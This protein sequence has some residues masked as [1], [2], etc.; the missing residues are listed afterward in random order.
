MQEID[1]ILDD[2]PQL[3]IEM[4]ECD[5]TNRQAHE[6]LQAYNDHRI[7]LYKHP[8]TRTRKHY[9]EQLSE[10][11]ELKRQRPELFLQEITNVSQNIR[12]IESNIR[13]KK[14]K[15][16][17]ELTSWQENLLKAN[18]KKTILMELISK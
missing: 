14:Y 2:Q 8:F 10:L 1:L 18:T 12:R 16:P 5:I 4:V 17:D 13:K 11:Y 15:T 6:E 7:F 9:A 3:A